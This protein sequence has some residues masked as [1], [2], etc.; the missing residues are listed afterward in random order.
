[1]MGDRPATEGLLS[2]NYW[3][4]APG[5]AFGSSLDGLGLHLRHIDVSKRFRDLIVGDER[6]GNAW[7]TF[8]CTL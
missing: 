8:T 1:M 4:L 2:A 3:D 7:D 6:I 5:D